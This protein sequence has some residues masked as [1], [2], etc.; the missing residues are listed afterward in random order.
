MYERSRRIGIV[1]GMLRAG[2]I[3]IA[4]I[5]SRNAVQILTF[6]PAC[7]GVRIPS[8]V[9]VFLW[10]ALDAPA[11]IFWCWFESRAG[12][13]INQTVIWTLILRKLW[14]SEFS[15]KETRLQLSVRLG[16]IWLDGDAKWTWV[17][18][19]RESIL[20]SLSKVVLTSIYAHKFPTWS[21]FLMRS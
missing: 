7:N 18:F 16:R 19:C 21:L 11:N 5:C 20:K 10:V 4:A 3:T 14:T 15:C 9:F 12:V 2:E 1:L 13:I 17:L 8:T 6:D